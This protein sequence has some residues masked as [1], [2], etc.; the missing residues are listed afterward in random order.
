MDPAIKQA[1]DAEQIFMSDPD[2]Y[3][4]YV[5]RQ[6]AIMDYNTNMRCAREDGLAEG[7]AEGKSEG[8]DRMARLMMFLY[9]KGEH[10]EA[11]LAMMDREARH[12]LYEKYHIE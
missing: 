12:R 2:T 3:L 11:R 5:N 1:M 9:D 8:E 6:M 7:K 10:E 4:R